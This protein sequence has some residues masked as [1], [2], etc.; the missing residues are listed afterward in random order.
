MRCGLVLLLFVGL[1]HCD[2]GSRQEAIDDL[3]VDTVESLLF[4]WYRLEDHKRLN[5]LTYAYEGFS[6]VVKR[7]GFPEEALGEL[8]RD[9]ESFIDVSKAHFELLSE[10]GGWSWEEWIITAREYGNE[11]RDSILGMKSLVKK[12]VRD[13]I[14]AVAYSFQDRM[15]WR[16]MG[17]DQSGGRFLD[18][19]ISVMT[20]IA[21]HS[22]DLERAYQTSLTG[23][24]V[25]GIVD[26]EGRLDR[27]HQCLNEFVV[28]LEAAKRVAMA[29]RDWE[30]C[31]RA[32]GIDLGE[33]FVNRQR[34]Y[35][36][37]LARRKRY[38]GF[39]YLD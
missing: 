14:W 39:T 36:D 32:V 11:V 34:L 5:A 19:S 13:Q 15:W 28:D 4:G 16:E 22:G 20:I 26:T 27:A 21:L 18:E 33:V 2:E 30:N 29:T 10:I 24:G 31:S 12:V 25:A 1:S 8:A 35:V 7:L 17:M 9:F 38:L 6:R 37:M 23:L 3:A